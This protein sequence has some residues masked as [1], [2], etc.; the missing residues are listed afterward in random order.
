M[1]SWLATASWVALVVAYAGFATAWNR[2]DPGW[3]AGL[4]RP[5]FQPPDTV[6]ALMWPL[7]FALLLGVGVWFTRAAASGTTWTAV[8]LLAASVAAAL[9]W[10]WLFYVPHRLAL[11]ALALA[12][13]T[14]LTWGLVTLVAGSLPWA[15]LALVPY[16]GWLTVAT[17]LSVAYARSH[18]RGSPPGS[19][20]R[21]PA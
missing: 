1:T 17:A 16:A 21:S 20:R 14:V 3:Y 2:H 15:G 19:R 4:T 10:A 11:A 13:A 18:G 6:F 8:V 5:S 9:C 7:S 12:G